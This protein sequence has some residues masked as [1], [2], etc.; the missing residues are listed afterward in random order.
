MSMIHHIGVILTQ[1]ITLLAHWIV[2]DWSESQADTVLNAMTLHVLG[3]QEV[4]IVM[5]PL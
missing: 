4:N 1:T 2:I 5:P 3:V